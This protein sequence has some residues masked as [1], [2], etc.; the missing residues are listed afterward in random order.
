MTPE[1]RQRIMAAHPDTGGSHD[2][3]VRLLKTIRPV[4]PVIPLSQED[5]ELLSLIEQGE[6]TTGALATVTTIPHTT[7]R[8]R[9]CRMERHGLI[10][11]VRQRVSWYPQRWKVVDVWRNG[12]KPAVRAAL[13][14][15]RAA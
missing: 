14:Q 2:A 5:A 8:R 1:M 4:K 9:L 13:K 15:W 3:A 12:K 10:H 6:H 7:V 11:S